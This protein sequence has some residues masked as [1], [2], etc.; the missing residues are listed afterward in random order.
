[1]K[2]TIKS[3]WAAVAA[4]LIGTAV[5]GCSEPWDEPQVGDVQFTVLPSIDPDTGHRFQIRSE[6]FRA[7]SGEADLYLVNSYKELRKYI[8]GYFPT[9]DFKRHSVLL[10]GGSSNQTPVQSDVRGLRYT[11]NGSYELDMEVTEGVLTMGGQW[12]TAILTDK[13][14][15]RS[16]IEWKLEPH[17]YDAYYWS[18]DEKVM[19]ESI[20]GKYYVMFRTED[21][22]RI[23]AELA[24]AGASLAD[25]KKYTLPGIFGAD[26]VFDAREMLVGLSTATVEG[27]DERVV[28]DVLTLT[29]YWAPY[30]MVDGITEVWTDC[31]FSV[32]LR[33]DADFPTL[34]KMAEENGVGIVE[35][36]YREG[37]YYLACTNSSKFKVVEMLNLF[38]EA[39]VFERVGTYHLPG[40]GRYD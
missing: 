25:A 7:P 13:M 22:P 19:L 12:L 38:H 27:G 21:Q 30:Y 5:G 33:S 36:N 31:V 6:Y 4:A 23:E 1:M 3:I 8:D 35:Y 37:V 17:V 2:T 18:G 20:D 16:R 28:K 29:F 26:R 9:V 15:G 14:S 10:I 24:K 32:K 40:I 34:E 11:S 39:G